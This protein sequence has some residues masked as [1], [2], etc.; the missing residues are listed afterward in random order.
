M[1]PLKFLVSLIIDDI[2]KDVD[3]IG[4]RM[5][6]IK[7]RGFDGA[8]LTVG[9]GTGARELGGGDAADMSG[10]LKALDEII[11]RAKAED[12]SA[13]LGITGR[14]AAA[15]P[16]APAQRLALGND[17]EVIKLTDPGIPS[18]F[19]EVCALEQIGGVYE[20]IKEGLSAEAFEYITGFCAEFPGFSDISGT[21]VPWYD[22]IEEEFLN[23]YGMDIKPFLKELF[24]EGGPSK[25]KARY[26]NRITWRFTK[27]RLEP[28]RGWCAQNGK[29]LI[30]TSETEFEPVNMIE[31]RGSYLESERGAAL[32]SVTV[33]GIG[34][35][36][37]FAASA[38]SGFACQTGNCEAAVS[39]FGGTGWGLMPEQFEN[40]LRKLTECGITTFVVN[41]CYPRLSGAALKRRHISFPEHVPW[42]GVIPEI[43]AELRR[44]AEIE[45][46]RARRILL[47]CPTRAM[48]SVYAPGGENAEAKELSRAVTGISDR[49][50]EMSRRFDVTDENMFENFA[51]AGGS[52]VI[53]GERSY[54]TLL[55]TPGCA[56]TKKGKLMLEKA[57][58]SGTRILNDIPKSD[59]EIIPLELIRD[60]LKEI[61]PIVVNQD[62]WTITPPETNILP[63]TPEYRNGGAEFRFRAGDD[64]SGAVRLLVSDGCREASIN[65][66]LISVSDRDERGEY[67]E[68][69]ENIVSGE[70]KIVLEGCGEVF[71]YLIGSFR[72]EAASGYRSFDQRQVQ[73]KNNFV[74]RPAGAESENNLVRCGYP[75]ADLCASAKKI[76][77]I[78]ENINRPVLR[79]RCDDAS[80]IEVYFDNEFIGRVYGGNNTLPI[81]PM[82]ADERH[83]VEIR[84]FPSGFNLYGDRAYV[85]GDTGTAA[86]PDE[87]GYRA[88]DNVKLVNWKIPR[89]IELIREF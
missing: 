63:L 67:Y 9:R 64:F 35:V 27:A 36:S 4:R 26:W 30:M 32:P 5:R 83:V 59:T 66:I 57:K 44:V 82:A 39:V 49:L 47:V 37:V 79:L 80:V 22:D 2:E 54:S 33:R 87:P 84:C 70:N 65:D 53:M 43:L 10:T 16:M 41:S 60:T 45:G 42:K 1:E 50:H 7:N 29:K 74:L 72:V 38:A 51:S 73:T 62:R 21:T 6:Q 8:V 31:E 3:I 68:I 52:G 15:L 23:D 56:F 76:I 24:S 34:D 85:F 58:A 11:L 18:P 14:R 71:A 81:P 13:W 69:T 12:L 88:D 25:L 78:E 40:C 75:F 48:W 89:E 20:K 46:K 55:I 61:V 17:G 19:D 77:Y 86:G 28:I